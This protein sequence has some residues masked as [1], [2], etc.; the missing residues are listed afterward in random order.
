MEYTVTLLDV[1]ERTIETL[2]ANSLGHALYLS[3]ERAKSKYNAWCLDGKL[4]EISSDFD[5]IAS[6]DDIFLNPTP[7]VADEDDEEE[8]DEDAAIELVG[9]GPILKQ[10]TFNKLP[11]DFDQRNVYNFGSYQDLTGFTLYAADFAMLKH[12]FDN[13]AN[14]SVVWVYP[15]YDGIQT[16]VS[17][18]SRVYA[19]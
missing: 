14:R 8:E 1:D 2:R 4:V 16:E 10:I 7:F 3:C 13:G 18:I 9:E 11:D 17:Y 15:A 19:H 6:Y 5:R 12:K